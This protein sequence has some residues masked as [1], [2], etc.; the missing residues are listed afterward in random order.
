MPVDC[1]RDMNKCLE[2]FGDTSIRN[3]VSKPQ[4]MQDTQGEKSASSEILLDL[5][6]QDSV[7][8]PTLNQTM[9]ST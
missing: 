6:P 9:S 4:K 7:L 2:M 5:H 3:L 8:N 1:A